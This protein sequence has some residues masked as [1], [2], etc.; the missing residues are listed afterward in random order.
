MDPKFTGEMKHDKCERRVIRFT[1]DKSKARVK[2]MVD[3]THDAYTR[4]INHLSNGALS[5]TEPD[6][7]ADVQTLFG[8]AR[9]Q[10]FKNVGVDLCNGCLQRALDAHREIGELLHDFMKMHEDANKR[11]R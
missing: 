10:K 2:T 3:M 7:Y 6:G 9:V 1:D 11:N 8:M 4:L 5:V